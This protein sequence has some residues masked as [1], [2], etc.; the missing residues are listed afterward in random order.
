MGILEGDG[1]VNLALTILA[2]AQRDQAP[3]WQDF[4]REFHKTIH[5]N[6]LPMCLWIARYCIDHKEE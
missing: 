6:I 5:P 4:T 1:Y 2:F 3:M